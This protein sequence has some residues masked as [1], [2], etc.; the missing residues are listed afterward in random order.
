MLRLRE[1]NELDAPVMFKALRIYLPL[2]SVSTAF[3]RVSS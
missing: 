3:Y 1:H 2:L